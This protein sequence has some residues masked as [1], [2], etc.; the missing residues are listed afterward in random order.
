MIFQP[1]P[2]TRSRENG[3]KPHFSKNCLYKKKLRFFGENR[4]S[5]LFYIYDGLTSCEFS[6]KSNDGK[7]ENFL[8]RTD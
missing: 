6:E 1:K 8:S 3:Q 7:Y 2:M 5:S 4:A